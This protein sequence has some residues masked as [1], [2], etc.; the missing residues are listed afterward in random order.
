MTGESRTVAQLRAL[1]QHLPPPPAPLE[2]PTKAAWAAAERALAPLPE[3]Y[4]EFV[5]TYGTGSIDGFLRGEG[6]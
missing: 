6:V 2:V 5:E 4:K 1:A 3:D